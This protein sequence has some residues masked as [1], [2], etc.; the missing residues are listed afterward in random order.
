MKIIL[1]LLALA[2][3]AQAQTPTDPHE[4]NFGA[5]FR[6]ER[7]HVS[8]ACGTF[9]SKSAGGCAIE[10]FTDHPFHIA[11]GSIAPQNGFGSAAP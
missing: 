2:A 7:R 8:E 4:S 1:L 3:A 11:A 9:S 6:T 10:L 5:D